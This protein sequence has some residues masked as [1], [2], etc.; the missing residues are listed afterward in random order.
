MPVGTYALTSTTNLKSYLNLT[1]TTHDTL[2]EKLIDRATG[3][4]ENFTNRN[5]KARDYHYDSAED[6]YDPDNAVLDGNGADRLILPQ[7]P[8]N[9]V[10]TLRVNEIEIDARESVYEC[11]YVIDK[12]D[13]VILL[14][15]YLFTRGIKNVEMAYNAGYATVPDDLEQATIEQAAWMF[16]QST[17]GSALLGEVSRSLPDGSIS[18]SA[19]DLLPQVKR[20]LEK[21][22]ARF[23]L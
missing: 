16:K 14:S 22:R 20:A 12:K 1:V 17:A 4:I 15:G 13:G 5:L 21:Y 18:F 8:I 2:L 19:A 7:R 9:S 10:T 11:G 3:L 6:A 23:A